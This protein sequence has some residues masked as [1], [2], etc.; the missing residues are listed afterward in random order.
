M[1]DGGTA[2]TLIVGGGRLSFGGDKLHI[3]K[4]V[5]MLATRLMFKT[6]D[7]ESNIK[8]FDVEG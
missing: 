5:E 6:S 8:V 7:Q 3:I 4:D 2:C 1:F